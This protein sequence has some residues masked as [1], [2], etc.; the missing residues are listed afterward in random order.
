MPYPHSEA[1]HWYYRIF[2]PDV[3]RSKL[4]PN[5]PEDWARLQV[6]D[7][8]S[9]KPAMPAGFSG[10]PTE[11]QINQLYAHVKSRELFF[12]ELG[13]QTPLLW[14][15]GKR[16][17]TAKEP[18]VPDKPKL[19]E[20]PTRDRERIANEANIKKYDAEVGNY[21]ELLD[22]NQKNGDAFWSAVEG[23]YAGRNLEQDRKEAASRKENAK[24]QE[25][26]NKRA[27]ADRLISEMMAP[28]PNAPADIFYEVQQ[29]MDGAVIHSQ[30]YNNELK[31]NGYDLP[32]N[33]K[34]NDR[35]AATINFAMLFVSSHMGQFL[36][37]K[38]KGGTVHA[39][40]L[41]ESGVNM[42]LTGLFGYTRPS[43]PLNECLGEAMK[44]GQEAISAYLDN[45]P[46]LLGQYLAESVQKIKKQLGG[47]GINTLTQDTV[48]GTKIIERLLELFEKN[49]DIWQATGMSEQDRDFMRG[50]VQM[51]KVYDQFA[52]SHMKYVAA[53][54]EGTALSREEKAEILV[55]TLLRRMV[56][57]ELAKEEKLVSENEAYLAKQMDAVQKD[58]EANAKFVQW[59]ANNV[60]LS[61]EDPDAYGKAYNRERHM[62]NVSD[63]TTY[64]SYE[65]VEH[66]IINQLGQPGML[67]RMRQALLQDPFI[68]AQANK[69]PL[70][71]TSEELA[72]TEKQY[73][74]KMDALIDQI[75]PSVGKAV[76]FGNLQSMLA[77][78]GGRLVIPQL[79]GKNPLASV[80]SL[81]K[82][83]LQAL[84]NPDYNT[85]SMLYEH[86]KNGNLY[87]YGE[88][89]DMP[90]RLT[91]DG[92]QLSTQ[93]VQQPEKP[94]R[95]MRFAN[96][97]TFGLAYAEE[98]RAADTYD[99]FVK[100]SQARGAAA[101]NVEA[102]PQ[103]EAANE[104]HQNEN[105]QPQNENEQLQNE[106]E[107]PQVV[108][109][110][111]QVV[112]KD[113][114][115]HLND[116]NEQAVNAC[117]ARMAFDDKTV[118]ENQLGINGKQFGNLVAMALGSPELSIAVGRR[119]N[120]Q[121]NNPE[122]NYPKILDHYVKHEQFGKQTK[123]VGFLQNAQREVLKGM[124]AAKKGDYSA[125]GKIIAH[126]LIQNN[127]VL[128]GQ[129]QL[130]DR[131]TFY[132]TL[133]GRALDLINGNEQLKQAVL[134]HLGNDTK[135]LDIANAARNISN[136][137]TEIMPRYQE[138]LSQFGQT[139]D[140]VRK[141]KDGKEY[142]DKDFLVV[143]NKINVA[144]VCQLFRIDYQM[145][146]GDLNLETTEYVKDDTAERLAEQLNKGRV[147][148][149]FLVDKNR[150]D[151][152]QDPVAMKRLYTEALKEYQ[153]K[154]APQAE[155]PELE[156][157]IEN[158]PKEM[159]ISGLV[160]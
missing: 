66:P 144:K 123:S 6:W 59:E 57:K 148:D 99:L 120:R 37:D 93:T 151:I 111:E 138:M 25:Y 147:L 112:V 69:S 159:D 97:I 24:L 26:Q 32:E 71:F 105:E 19:F 135:Q 43:Q 154:F 157:N 118:P 133:G 11:E 126:G 28:R 31:P 79:K 128:L 94:S 142:K 3:Q 146:K 156:R 56:E 44:M 35:D 13:Q 16:L 33:N 74:E 53:Q 160:P 115:K 41:A 113:E 129:K 100:E 98:C 22:V 73:E 114:K 34:L 87:F 75:Q 82:G 89:K 46:Q 12:F 92:A 124:E 65:T 152:L 14:L 23:Y 47:T 4:L 62:L 27:R 2:M 1:I 96:F 130:D 50:Y 60:A 9:L 5:K 141:D 110:P 18:A 36:Y 77:A 150:V 139:R 10:V 68:L 103:Q 117:F 21:Q 137:R 40:T 78:D 107:Q 76:W 143:G 140:V 149:N 55:D 145:R 104:Q 127:K 67:E 132:A 54:T 64:A 20:N 52:Q 81:L 108:P 88:G 86:A 155:Q 15:E 80:E 153:Q 91:A 42:M 61:R 17:V 83:G 84:Q 70:E 90:V 122:V 8:N 106:N 38:G 63:Y 49:P 121:Y 7:G 136:L 45:K 39:A 158:Q 131:F 51:G 85:L 58:M 125:L 134:G 95:W 116:Y 48:A 102:E 30:Y 72:V 119:D 109:A 101:Q 29:H